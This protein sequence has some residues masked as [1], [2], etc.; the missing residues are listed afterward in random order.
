[1]KSDFTVMQSFIA[2][3]VG[4]EVLRPS[5]RPV[6]ADQTWRETPREHI[7]KAIAVSQ[8]LYPLLS[9][10]QHEYS[11]TFMRVSPPA[12]ALE[13]SEWPEVREVA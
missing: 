12:F 2:E 11:Y 6:P 13:E 8:R 7:R 5:M 9:L 3:R 10:N 4:G 1:M